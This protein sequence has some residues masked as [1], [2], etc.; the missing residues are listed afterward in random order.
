MRLIP[1]FRFR[2][3]TARHARTVAAL[4]ALALGTTA[5]TPSP[6]SP[7]TAV[8]PNIVILLA[9]DL[10]IGE[11]GA[12]GQQEI[13]TPHI[14]QLAREGMRFTEFRS[15]AAVCG[16]ARCSLMTGLHNG[17]CR[18]DDNDNDF[19][20]TEDV[21]LA[22]RLHDAGYV[23]AQTLVLDGGGLSPFPLPRPADHA[24][25]TP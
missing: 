21:T 23:T 3:R 10:G 9:D 12:W 14:D 7:A 5:C 25:D 19:L 15:S 11:L 2:S 1:R 4:G 20:R 17:T 22:E 24:G 8:P 16:P 13:T 18:L 6:R